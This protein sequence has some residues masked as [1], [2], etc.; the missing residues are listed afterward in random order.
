MWSFSPEMG[1][2][3]TTGRQNTKKKLAKVCNFWEY[4]FHIFM[5][6]VHVSVRTKKLLNLNMKK[7]IINL[8][9]IIKF[10]SLW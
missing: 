8:F 6:K 3:G 10:I 4:F 9:T 1:I 7:Y 5:V 2:M